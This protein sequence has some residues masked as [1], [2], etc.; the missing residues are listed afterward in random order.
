[1]KARQRSRREL[2]VGLLVTVAMLAGGDFPI[3]AAAQQPQVTVANAWARATPPHAETAA[4][5][6]TLTSEMDDRLMNVSTPVAQRAE[7]HRTTDEG[8]VMRMRP[9]T[10]GLELPARKPVSLSP[11]G[12]H[13]M[14][15]GL[16]APLL[17]GKTVPLH[18]TFEHAAPID[19][20]ATIQP[21]SGGSGSMSG[22]K[23]N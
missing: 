20:Q 17:A 1:M 15:I 10:G 9:V 3:Q 21:L 12:Y 4:A 19:I 23:M 14:L 18:L 6:M 7:L 5:Y 22:M 8:G 11:G 16:K 13:L 2:L